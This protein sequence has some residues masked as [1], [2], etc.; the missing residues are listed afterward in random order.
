M[1]DVPVVE[2]DEQRAVPTAWR[3]VLRDVVEAVRSGNVQRASDLPS[4]GAVP[5]GTAEIV[6]DQVA[7]Y[8]ETLVPLPEAAWETSVVL[9]QGGWWQVLV[10][11]WT[12]ESGRSDLVL[13]VQVFPDGAG[14]RFEVGS[15]HVP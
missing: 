8:G 11:L 3:P 2:D 5:S 12:A 7:E 6:L 9:W 15:V 4:V 10:D 13:H 1:T 14:H